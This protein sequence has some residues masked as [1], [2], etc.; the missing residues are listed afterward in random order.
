[1]GEKEGGGGDMTVWYV[2]TIPIVATH[3]SLVL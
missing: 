1:M 2:C 3:H